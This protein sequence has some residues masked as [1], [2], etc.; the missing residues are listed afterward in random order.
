MWRMFY[1]ASSVHLDD[2]NVDEPMH[3]GILE[4]KDLR[5]EWTRVVDTPIPLPTGGDPEDT[6]VLGVGS[7]KL[8]NPE[9]RT[10]ALCNRVWINDLTNTTGSTM[11]LI[12]S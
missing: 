11:A 2:S 4:A 10:L 8:L 12:S 9:D 1:S 6:T 3:H 5:G 7:L